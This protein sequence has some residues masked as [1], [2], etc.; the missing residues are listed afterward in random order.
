MNKIAQSL[1]AATA[2][3]VLLAGC[4][5]PSAEAKDAPEPSATPSASASAASESA[6][7]APIVMSDAPEAPTSA[8]QQAGFKDENDMY[9]R[10]IKSAWSGEL[11]SDEQLLAAAHYVCDAVTGGVPRDQIKAV[12]GE[13]DAATNNNRNLIESAVFAFCP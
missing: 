6:P 4:S 1:I 3:I 8:A 2:A 11:P 13:G 9:M 10:G 5:S 12:T 7:P